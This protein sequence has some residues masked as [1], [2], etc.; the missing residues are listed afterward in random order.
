MQMN[1]EYFSMDSQGY[2]TD[3]ES[4]LEDLF[5]DVEN[6]RKFDA[7]LNVMATRIA[8]VFASLKHSLLSCCICYSLST[9]LAWKVSTASSTLRLKN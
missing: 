1:L 8:T 2:T 7:C 3:Q 6:S 5:G 4:A 9:S